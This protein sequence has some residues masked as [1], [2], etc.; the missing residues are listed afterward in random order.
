MDKLLII[1]I[2]SGV[3]VQ[4]VG[5]L[6]SFFLT[7]GTLRGETGVTERNPHQAGQ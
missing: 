1:K 3:I 4:P 7:D 5:K 6:F 2:F